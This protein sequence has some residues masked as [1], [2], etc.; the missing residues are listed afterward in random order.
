MKAIGNYIVIEKLTEKTKEVNGLLIT[1]KTDSDNRYVK[2]KIISTGDLVK[3]LKNDDIIYYDKN[4]GNG[5]DFEG[6][7]YTVIKDLDVVLVE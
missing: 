6:K 4:R 2:A 3:I 5:I 7:V 1:E